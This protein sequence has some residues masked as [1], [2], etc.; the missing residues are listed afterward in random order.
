MEI[1]GNW[2]IV[3]FQE[4]PEEPKT[5]PGDPGGILTSMGVYVFN[6]EVLVRRLIED[7]RSHSDHDFGKDIIPM[8][9]EKDQIYRLRFQAGGLRG[10]GILERC[11]DDRCLL[12]GQYGSDLRHPSTQSL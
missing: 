1:D 3:G 7:A 2:R 6:T 8:M 5:I 10:H 11:G 4:K 12:R 9:I